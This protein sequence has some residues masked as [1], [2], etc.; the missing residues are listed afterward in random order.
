MEVEGE[1]AEGGSGP[2]AEDFLPGG[3]AGQQG[4]AGFAGLGHLVVPTLQPIVEGRLARE[5]VPD[6][7]DRGQG[8]DRYAGRNR[9]LVVG[10]GEQRRQ[11]LRWVVGSRGGVVEVFPSTGDFRTKVFEF[12]R[13]GGE[14]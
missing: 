6:G 7:F 12:L 9:R 11:G 1:A 10:F 3:G 5:G 14:C 2:A 13:G 8:F 4:R